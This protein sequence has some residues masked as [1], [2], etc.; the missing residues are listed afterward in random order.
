M[1]NVFIYYGLTLQLCIYDNVM[2]IILM[3]TCICLKENACCK[4]IFK[5]ITKQIESIKGTCSIIIVKRY[6]VLKVYTI[7]DEFYFL[8]I[9]SSLCA[10]LIY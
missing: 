7:S 8:N 5:Y 4:N 6:L 1:V 3:Y 9:L 2:K 10:L